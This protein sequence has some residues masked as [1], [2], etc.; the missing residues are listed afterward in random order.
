MLTITVTAPLTM[1]AAP[2]VVLLVMGV[3]F[4]DVGFAVVALVV[5]AEIGAAVGAAVDA[6][7]GTVMKIIQKSFNQ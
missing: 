1:D 6:A 4:P 3:V 7:V 5:D 2:D